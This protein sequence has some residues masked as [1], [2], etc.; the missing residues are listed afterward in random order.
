MSVTVMLGGETN[1]LTQALQCAM[2]LTK[3]LKTTLTGLC[4]VPDPARSVMYV[5]GPEGVMM[6]SAAIDTLSEAQ[7][8]L[9]ADLKQLFETGTENAPWLKSDFISQIGSVASH[10]VAA[11]L[12]ADALVL[13]RHATQSGHPL[14]TAFEHVL[15]DTHLPLILAPGR[16]R[17]SDTCLIAWDASPLAA[18]AVRMHMPLITSYKKAV[19]VQHPDKLRYEWASACGDSLSQLKTLLHQHRMD[20]TEETLSGKISDALMEAADRHQASLLVMGAY[21][22]N[23]LGELLFG[24]T[25]SAMIHSLSGPALALCH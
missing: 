22:H 14:N 23:R 25:T 11:G 2:D 3:R 1:D 6:G 4:A 24:G 17:D 13:P 21:G 15:M 7:D 12:L 20:V 10:G 19:L 8:K 5:T 18:R 9:I 16:A